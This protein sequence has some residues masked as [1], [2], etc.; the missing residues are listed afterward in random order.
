MCVTEDCSTAVSTSA[1]KSIRLWDLV[2]N[3][4]RYIIYTNAFVPCTVQVSPEG[5][6]IVSACSDGNIRVWEL[7]NGALL[8]E[9]VGHGSEV[10]SASCTKIG[11]G[12]LLV[13]ASKNGTVRLWDLAEGQQLG[14]M[15][16][17]RAST[18]DTAILISSH[19][20]QA[21]YGAS[22][23]AICIW[24]CEALAELAA[25][26]ARVCSDARRDT[27]CGTFSAEEDEELAVLCLR[28]HED[29]VWSVGASADGRYLV[30]GSDD[31][32]VRVW[33]AHTGRSLNTLE[34]HTAGVYS[35]CISRDG[36]TIAS[37]SSDSTICVWD[38]ATGIARHVLRGHEGEVNSVCITRFAD[39]II[40][41]LVTLLVTCP[42]FNA[43]H[44][45]SS[46][47]EVL[48]T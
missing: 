47:F 7:S 36:T 19:G 8:R 15:V 24:R 32:T 20:I 33:D 40:S 45:S 23:G 5:A 4:P 17:G 29:N 48:R 16:C 42:H 18:H 14:A 12:S 31:Y 1:D 34:G 21:V 26:K 3:G 2:T 44:F 35:V 10:V 46:H 39:K 28:G 38:T 30:S 37:G 22:D 11:Q 43:P 6:H 27:A 41:G 9:L 13:S 25:W